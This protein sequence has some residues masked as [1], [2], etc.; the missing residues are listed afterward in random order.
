MN[1]PGDSFK[2]NYTQNSTLLTPKTPV[3]SWTIN[4]L[5]FSQSQLRTLRLYNF[6][7]PQHTVQNR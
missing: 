5:G 6:G 2:H 1:L 3:Q 7:S 4:G